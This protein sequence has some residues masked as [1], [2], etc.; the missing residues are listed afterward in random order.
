MPVTDFAP[1]PVYDDELLAEADRVLRSGKLNY[2]CGDEGRRFE[3]EFAEYVNCRYGVAVANGTVA[4]ELAL[5]SLG[6]GP[7][8]EVIV[9][10]RTFIATASSVVRCGATPMFADVDSVSQTI[11]ADAIR[12]QL[13][14][15]TAAVI[16]V[17]L[18][19]WPCDMDPI[20]ELARSRRL[21]VIEDCAQ[22]HGARYK[23]RV[24]G[25][26]GD[27]GAYSF[28]QDKIM[29]TAGEGGMLV[30]SRR[31]VW[32][33]AWSLKDHGKDFEAAHQP[34][35]TAS[36]RWL[37]NRIG[38][39]GRMTEL[40]A[41]IG[42]VALRK[43]DGWIDKRRRNAVIL[44]EHFARLP[45]LRT[46]VPPE[47][48]FHSYYKYYAFVRRERLRAGW[49]RDGILAAIQ[50]AG[51]PCFSGSCSEVYLERAFEAIGRPTQRLYVARELGETS[52]MFLVHPTLSTDHMLA[53]GRHVAEVMEQA[54]ERQE[55]ALSTVAA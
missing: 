46:T 55:A 27:I 50:Q 30:T 9:P 29:T 10:S 31:D 14:P 48:I 43:L 49:D 5:L 54:T 25:S 26:I 53:A 42:R 51:V 7:G 16:V 40:Q 52:L 33:H 21:S 13:T 32:Q 18:A 28:C 4:L 12:Q 45:A 17:H 44:T 47:D 41:A 3:Q 34:H 37:H 20:L 36:F 8:D 35:S 24:V 2:W 23:G 6:I 38:T 15:R 1:W 11:T 22:A 19:G 39:N